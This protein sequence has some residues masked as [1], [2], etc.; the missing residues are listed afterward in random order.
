MAQS[1]YFPGVPLGLDMVPGM[2]G[3]GRGLEGKRSTGNT[4][5]HGGPVTGDHVDDREA[6]DVA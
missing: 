5:G 4:R 3:A 6:G 2:S 1:W